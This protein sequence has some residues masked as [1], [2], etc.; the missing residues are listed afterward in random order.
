MTPTC[1][2]GFFSPA[3]AIF[4]FGSEDLE[5]GFLCVVNTL[6]HNRLPITAAIPAKTALLSPAPGV[7]LGVVGAGDALSLLTGLPPPYPWEWA[8][9]GGLCD[10]AGGST[11]EE[12][13][14]TFLFRSASL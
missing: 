9:S 6:K 5:T 13:T 4:S 12:G 8:G 1:T 10:L 7:G 3:K 14:G 11:D 2:C